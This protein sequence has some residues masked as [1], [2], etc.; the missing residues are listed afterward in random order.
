M[1]DWMNRPATVQWHPAVPELK[2]FSGEI[3]LWFTDLDQLGQ[4]E[5]IDSAF[6]LLDE[7]EQGRAQRFRFPHL[8]NRFVMAHARLRQVLGRYLQQHPASLRF[9]YGD[10]GKPALADSDPLTLQFNLSHSDRYAL[11]A[12][13]EQPLGVDLEQ[14]QPFPSASSLAQRFFSAKEFEVLQTLDDPTR[15]LA[16]LRHWVCKEAYVKATGEG[17][18]TQLQR[19]VV[20]FDTQAH[21]TELPGYSASGTWTG[22]LPWQLLELT[23][24]AETLAALVVPQGDPIRCRYWRF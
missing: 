6:G 13:G 16:F 20:N 9:C 14:V 11:I 23:P 4:D 18:V 5:T 3:H 7:Q 1:I 8:K 15:S 19:V 17:L 24:S 10:R 21:F 22:S 12:L 2:L